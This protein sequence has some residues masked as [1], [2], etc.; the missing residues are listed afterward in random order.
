MKGVFVKY[1][2][3]FVSLLTMVVFMSFPALGQSTRTIYVPQGWV[4]VTARAAKS[5]V[6]GLPKGLV[7]VSQ[8]SFCKLL[9]ID[10]AT[11]S[12]PYP[13]Y[14]MQAHMPQLDNMK[15][16]DD[17]LNSMEDGLKASMKNHP[18]KTLVE[19]GTLTVNGMK[20]FHV[21]VDMGMYFKETGV[22]VQARMMQYYIPDGQGA[23]ILSFM[24]PRKDWGKYLSLF[25]DVVAKTLE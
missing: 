5:D 15:F 11:A 23:S 4:N 8:S 2:F 22:T 21:V 25:Q 17:S 14:M 16:T 18:T 24:A 10:P 20:V 6:D 19:I 13:V 1:Y 9:A 12:D 3:K 7:Q